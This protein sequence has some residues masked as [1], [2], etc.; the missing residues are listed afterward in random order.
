M[1]KTT[2]TKYNK[3]HY[4]PE[5]LAKLTSIMQQLGQ[6]INISNIYN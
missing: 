3:I 4:K 5:E 1:T 6:S 2:K